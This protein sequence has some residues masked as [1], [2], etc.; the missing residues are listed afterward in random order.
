MDKIESMIEA[1]KQAQARDGA[2][3]LHSIRPLITAFM[4]GQTSAQFAMQ[5]LVLLCQC[6]QT[7]VVRPAPVVAVPMMQSHHVL[8]STTKRTRKHIK[9]PQTGRPWSDEQ[10]ARL[11]EMRRAGATF[12][13]TAQVFGRTSNA[14]EQAYR[15]QNIKSRTH[16]ETRLL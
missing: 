14:C 5:V 7:A 1:V 10:I 15:K 6:V 12:R 8:T 11:V 13:R 16:T 2:V 4:D 3:S 9:R